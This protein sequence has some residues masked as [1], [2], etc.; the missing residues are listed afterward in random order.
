MESWQDQ[1]I[2]LH[3]RPHGE[4]GAV[5]S[6]LTENHGRHAGYV[7]GATSSK[8]RGVLQAGNLVGVEWSSRTMEQLGAFR[9][10]QI[11][12]LASSFWNDPLR[13]SALMSACALCDAGLPEREGHEGL[14]HGLLSLFEALESENW[15]ATYL[16][17]E[18]MLLRELGF[19][20][21]FKRCASTGGSEDLIYMS[22]KS[23][24]AV[25]AAAGAPCKLCGM[26]GL[27]MPILAAGSFAIIFGISSIT[28]P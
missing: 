14:F 21:D 8:M 22:P 2:V 18:I 4:N 15:A 27:A 12:L 11:R 25:S 10:E 3:I 23:G 1:A 6:V 13:L 26:W 28:S 7:R 16:F 24:R 20:L 17:W 9:L 19:A 5:V